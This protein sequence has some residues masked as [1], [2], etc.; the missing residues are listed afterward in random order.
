MLRRI[1]FLIPLLGAALALGL[2][3][4]DVKMQKY[5]KKVV[6]GVQGGVQPGPLAPE[7]IST[8][9]LFH[10]HFN[11]WDTLITEKQGAAIAESFRVEEEGKRLVFLISPEAKFSNGR[12]ILAEDVKASLE[13]LIA[14]EENGHINAKSA[15]AEIRTEDRKITILLNRPTP[16]F[17]YLLSTPEFGIVPREILN[18]KGDIESLSVTSGAYTAGALDYE[19][20]VVELTRNPFF[21]RFVD[22]APEMVSL[23]FLKPVGAESIGAVLDGAYD[24]LE[25]QN[26]EA[27]SFLPK[28]AQA[29][30]EHH[31]SN[32]SIS[33]FLI[34]NSERI[35]GNQAQAIAGV[36]QKGFSYGTLNSVERPSFQLFPPKTFGSL[37]TSEIPKLP[38]TRV[39]LPS[40]INLRVVRK[41]GAYVNEVKRVFKSAGIEVRLVDRNDDVPFDYRLTGQGMNTEYPEIELHLQILSPY[42]SFGVSDEIKAIL[43][44]AEASTDDAIRSVCIK[45]I[46]RKLLES[47][48][49]IP[50]TLQGYVHAFKAD[51]LDASALATYDGNIP[52]YEMR[53]KP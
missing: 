50:L 25:F 29:G 23:R 40:V 52:L 37:A 13:R 27:D 43:R 28:I 46:G 17:L 14:R 33:V 38:S 7:N 26:S 49:I 39:A 32:P 20:Q 15:I 9:P 2:Y 47:G 11:L 5:Q 51:R 18:E 41:D 4:K 16:A 42:A 48:K 1:A 35:D 30:Y 45:T 44:K 53:V 3:W 34:A 21:R 36:F 24:F 6:V 31:V 8:I 19:K 22:G 10:L 12:A